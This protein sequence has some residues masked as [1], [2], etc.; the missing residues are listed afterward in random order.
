MLLP[1]LETVSMPACDFAP[2]GGRPVI[3]PPYWSDVAHYSEEGFRAPALL[4][5]R[6]LCMSP[7]IPH[8][9]D[10]N[11]LLFSLYLIGALSSQ[12]CTRPRS[13]A[14]LEHV[15]WP[16]NVAGVLAEAYM[17]VSCIAMIASGMTLSLEV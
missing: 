5:S 7:A 8:H 14:S 11:T 1:V 15:G 10:L 6:C 12:G 17:V 2:A 4:Q 16:N 9:S 3:P 13:S